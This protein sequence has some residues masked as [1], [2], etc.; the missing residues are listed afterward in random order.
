[1][2]NGGIRLGLKR[3]AG[4]TMTDY[5]CWIHWHNASPRTNMQMTVVTYMLPLFAETIR[6]T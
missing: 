2:R 6:S 1:M 3:E 4:N 5:K